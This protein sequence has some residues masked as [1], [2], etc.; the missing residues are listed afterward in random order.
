MSGERP[1]DEL[2]SAYV[3]GELSPEDAAR[4]EAYMAAHPASRGAAEDYRRLDTLARASLPAPAA[5]EERWAR[6][7]EAVLAGIAGRAESTEKLRR[8]RGRVFRVR[9]AAFAAGLLAAAACG[10]FAVLPARPER[11]VAAPRP[12][13][14]IEP[15]SRY[16]P[17]VMTSADGRVVGVTILS[18]PPSADG[19]G[20]EEGEEPERHEP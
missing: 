2:V 3:D 16:I 20:A 11:E 6:V 15:G 5:P 18:L 17:Q 1:I 12:V 14:D 7:R 19:D 9:A 4:V 10:L 8:R 13:L